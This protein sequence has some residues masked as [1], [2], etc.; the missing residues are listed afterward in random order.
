MNSTVLGMLKPRYDPSRVPYRFPG[1]R[2]GTRYSRNL[3]NLM[4][5]TAHCPVALTDQPYTQLLINVLLFAC[6]Y[7]VDRIVKSNI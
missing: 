5:K 4:G 7:F 1:T 6:Y 2:P 3:E